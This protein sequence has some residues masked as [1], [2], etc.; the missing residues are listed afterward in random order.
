MF[1]VADALAVGVARNRLGAQD[2]VAHFHGSRMLRQ[3][4]PE[5]DTFAAERLELLERCAAYATV[6]PEGIR[7]SHGTAAQLHGIPVPGRLRRAPLDVA[8]P[9]ESIQPRGKGIRGHR[10]RDDG[11][12]I[13]EGM[14]AVDA[15]S[16][17]LQ[18][19]PVLGLD[20]LIIAGDALVRR[21]RP[22]SSMERLTAAVELAAGQ[23][24]CRMARAALAGIR[25][26]TDSP[27]ESRI[28]LILV[29]AGLPEPVVGHAVIDHDG[30]FVGTP[31]LAYV[32]R[33]IAIEYEGDVHRTD[34]RTFRSDIDRREAFER[35]DWRVLRVTGDHVRQPRRLVAR[36]A[37]LLGRRV[38]R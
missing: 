11:L 23:R 6:A 7:F 24:G 15:E 32:A 34:L 2:L 5:S 26:G 12:V 16:A 17:W 20:D 33:R 31:D 30:Y 37:E 36:V 18:L 14:P 35:I 9:P 4:H 21:K 1:S 10:I 22:L 25:P 29:G 13:V 3:R 28:R 8:V 38:P 27:M 19:S